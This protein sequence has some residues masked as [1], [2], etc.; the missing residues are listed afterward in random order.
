MTTRQ[1]KAAEQLRR[2]FAKGVD[3]KNR[4]WLLSLMLQRTFVPGTQSGI[5]LSSPAKA[6]R[7]AFSVLPCEEGKEIAVQL[8]PVLVELIKQYWNRKDL[9]ESY[10]MSLLIAAMVIGYISPQTSTSLRQSLATLAAGDRF[11]A[12]TL[13][14]GVKAF[15]RSIKE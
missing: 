8:S 2:L 15:W 6:I 3:E 9:Q 7:D 14:P 13:K 10:A 1:E 4:C 5:K 12:L 11:D